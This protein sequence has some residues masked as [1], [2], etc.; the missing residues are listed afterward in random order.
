MKKSTSRIQE[1]FK[2]T[3]E[4]MGIVY[5]PNQVVDYI[6]H[7]TDRLLYKEFGYHL[8]DKGIHILDAFTG[9]GTFI[10]DLINDKELMPDN[11]LTYKYENEIHCNEIMLLA[12]YIATINIEHAFHS[13]IG[14]EYKSFPGA[15]LTDTFQMYEENDPLD[16][17][18]FIENSER[19]LRQIETPIHVLIGNPPWSALQ[20]SENDNNKN[21]AYPTLDA[22]IASTYVAQ[23]NAT[24]TMK[25]YDSYIRAFRWASDRIQDKGI[26]SFVTNAG[27]LRGVSMDGFR[28][29]LSN[30][31][32]SIYVFDLRGNQRTQGEESRKEGGKIFGSGSRAPVAITMLVRNPDSE[33]HGV[34][35]YHDVGD[36]LS[37]EEKL[38]QVGLAINGEHFD[39]EYIIPDKYGDWFS[40]RNELFSSFL[41]I[42]LAKLKPP[43]GAFI[44]YSMGVVT[45][46]D[47][48]VINFSCETV[49][50]SVYRCVSFYNEEMERWKQLENAVDVNNFV[51]NDPSK[52]SWTRS[53]K[54]RL[55]R[56]DNLDYS[57]SNIRVI[58]YRPFTKQFLYFDRSLNEMVYQ[59]DKLWPR[60]TSKNLMICVSGSKGFTS[61]ISDHLVDLHYIGDTQCFPLYFYEKSNDGKYNRIDA[62]TDETLNF[63]KTTYPRGF[64]GR[65]VKKGGPQISKE[66]IFYYIYGIFH[67]PEYRQ[68]FEANLEKELPRIPMSE[69]F[70]KFSA[71]G[72]DLARIHLGYEN[73]E[74]YPLKMVGNTEMPGAV[75]KMKW[76][77]KR[78]P[79]TKKMEVDKSVLIYNSSLTFKDIPEAAHKYIVNGRTPLEWM[80]DRYQVK[81]DK[82]SG[83]VNDPNKYS[84]DPLYIPNLIRRLI[85]VSVETVR[86]INNM[87][88]ISEIDCTDTMPEMWK[89]EV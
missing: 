49:K 61:L 9:T 59:Q 44:I 18:M 73:A 21:E 17:E 36:Y 82:A 35:H 60:S 33:K 52:I 46:R 15:V 48:W 3:S 63:F 37:R 51:N 83:I 78:N 54:Q 81:T 38:S 65:P 58:F 47:A 67:S 75:T 26:V 16:V 87:P 27:W 64:T 53:L 11:E 23:S 57:E 25:L 12:Y 34:I 85:T 30:E 29:T 86:I 4:K 19:V 22:K 20:R 5:T 89:L 40:Q 45:N 62:I 80:I 1:A 13:R 66:D 43:Y 74:L 2:A 8:Y 69:N 6:L 79:I 28:K 31:F 42:G 70:I 77:K 39:W 14:G 68:R 50:D 76:G 32:D 71:A 55:K 10:V 24:G 88:L 56:K 72:R 7:A 41:P 84:E